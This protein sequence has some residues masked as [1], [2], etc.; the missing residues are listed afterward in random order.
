MVTALGSV[1]AP[2]GFKFE[3]YE[4]SLTRKADIV[5]ALHDSFAHMEAALKATRRAYW[6]E[7]RAYVESPILDRYRLTPGT[8]ITGPAIVEERE[9]TTV[10][11]PGCVAT[12]DEWLNLT[13]TLPRDGE[14]R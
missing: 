3:T 14:V 12:V 8:Q 4:Q 10:I 11:P 7:H 2:A 9:S 1:P 6:P 5:K 13:V